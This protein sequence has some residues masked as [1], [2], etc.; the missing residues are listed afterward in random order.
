MRQG[1]GFCSLYEL[2]WPIGLEPPDLDRL[3]TMVRPAG[4]LAAGSVLFRSGDPFTA[5]YAVRSG[6]I[7]SYSID[8]GGHE[9]V[10][11]FHLRGEILGFDAVY[12]DR[13]RCNA[14]LLESSSFCVIPYQDIARLSREFPGL[15]DKVLRL[16]GREF[17][18]QL[19]FAEGTSATQRIANFLLDMRSRLRMA[20]E[21]DYELTLPM[22]RDD[23][24]N[25]LGI[26]PETLSR[27]FAKLE[28]NGLI[29]ADR[30]HVFLA[31]PIRLDLI[32]QGVN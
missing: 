19:M 32:A 30:R 4:P 21:V 17:S 2:C 24:A 9:L 12:P 26:T 10:H 14:L 1:C 7:K 8:A 11:G 25:Y 27:L 15:H 23:I 3:Q 13:H 18:R 6:C 31:D 16:M 22:S 29:D 28:R 20:G 5:I